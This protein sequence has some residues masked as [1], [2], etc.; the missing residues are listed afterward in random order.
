MLLARC[1]GCLYTIIC[2]L[3]YEFKLNFI[4][5]AEHD[6]R[7]RER[8]PSNITIR[9]PNKGGNRKVSFKTGVISASRLNVKK[10][11]F[12]QGLRAAQ[13]DEDDERMVDFDSSKATTFRRRNSPIP[14]N[15]AKGLVENGAG[16][17]QVTVCIKIIIKRVAICLCTLLLLDFTNFELSVFIDSTWQQI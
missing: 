13:F 15:K 12:E 8:N 10:G 11:N 7:D 1:A 9:K 4:Y 16:W 17:Y 2:M 5:F 3:Q 6:D 14:R